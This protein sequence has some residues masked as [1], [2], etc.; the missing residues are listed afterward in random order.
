MF[1]AAGE[2]LSLI[3]I[4]CTK[5]VNWSKRKAYQLLEDTIIADDG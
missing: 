2:P 3:I 5:H 1:V 4:D